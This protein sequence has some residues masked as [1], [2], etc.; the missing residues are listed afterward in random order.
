MAGVHTEIIGGSGGNTLEY[1]FTASVAG[2]T[3][4]LD[5]M[6]TVASL[7]IVNNFIINVPAGVSVV[8]PVSGSLGKAAFDFSAHTG[9]NITINNAG[10]ISSGNGGSVAAG[11]NSAPCGGAKVTGWAVSSTVSVPAEQGV[12][13]GTNNVTVTK[14][15]AK[16]GTAGSN[17]YY[18]ASSCDCDCN[19]SSCSSCFIA[20]TLVTMFD[21]TKKPIEE[22]RAGDIVLGA[23]G[24]P[25]EVTHTITK[26]AIG[27]DIYDVNGACTTPEHP[28]VNGERKGFNVPSMEALAELVDQEAPG[29]NKDG[30][31]EIINY[32]RP[33]LAK[34]KEFEPGDTVFTVNGSVPAEVVL[35]DIKVE[36]VYHLAL[37]GG[38]RTYCVNGVFVTGFLDDEAFKKYFM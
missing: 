10:T 22:V 15:P 16:Q 29:L 24:E 5:K 12:I 32:I 20:G 23:F 2:T 21:G 35:T 26:P 6:F 14:N 8:G 18:V 36:E 38:S 4:T 19:C 31:M 9:R 33:K 11:Y 37:N 13:P 34:F 27:T 30:V 25:N 3:F 1:N 17:I 28:F 7:A